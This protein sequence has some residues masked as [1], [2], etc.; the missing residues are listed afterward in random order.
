M[1]KGNI[2]SDKVAQELRYCCC[3]FSEMERE[4]KA[5]LIKI[6]E[7]KYF[8]KTYL[9]SFASKTAFIMFHYVSDPLVQSDNTNVDSIPDSC[10]DVTY[11]G[12]SNK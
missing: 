4:K 2:S 12:D 9:A 11:L 6:C 5:K 1:E 7:T 10:P 8:S 3:F